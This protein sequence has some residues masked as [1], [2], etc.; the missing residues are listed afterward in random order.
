MKLAVVGILPPQKLANATVNDL[1]ASGLL[2]TF[3]T[4]TV[5]ALTWNGCLVLRVVHERGHLGQ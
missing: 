1:S 3:Q 4:S 5:K 2:S